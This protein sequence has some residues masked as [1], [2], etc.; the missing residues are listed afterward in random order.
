MRQ[1]SRGL[2]DDEDVI[3]VEKDV[4]ATITIN[5]EYA[6]RLEVFSLPCP[7]FLQFL[8]LPVK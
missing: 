8:V 1:A 4:D 6:A 3:N 2:L 7:A 5:P